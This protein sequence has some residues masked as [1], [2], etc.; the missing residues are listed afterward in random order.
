MKIAYQTNGQQLIIAKEKASTC[1]LN[2]SFQKELRS[3]AEN[4]GLFN[5]KNLSFII[6]QLIEF[7]AEFASSTDT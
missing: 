3:Q 1:S 6:F 4:V 7:P 5:Y 2:K